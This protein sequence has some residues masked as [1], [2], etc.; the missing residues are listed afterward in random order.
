VSRPLAGVFV[1]GAGRRMGGTAKGLLRAPDG[2]TLIER[3]RGLLTG[4]GCDVVLVGASD[5][6]AVAKAGGGARGGTEPGEEAF[7]SIADDPP[8]VGPLGGLCALLRRAGARPALALA[9]DLPFVSARLLERLVS[10]PPAGIVA[11]RH[12]GRWEP[13]FARYEAAT[14]L[15]VALDL[16][17]QGRRALQALLDAAG[18]RP[19]AVSDQE[20]LELRDWDTPDDV[21]RDT[22]QR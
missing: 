5:A 1:G 15:P 19:L 13:L 4:A 10:A 18:A 8:G 17:A 6:Y 22:Y 9:C 14:A 20:L 12:D 21:A 7:E 2:V 3:W 11:P 16:L